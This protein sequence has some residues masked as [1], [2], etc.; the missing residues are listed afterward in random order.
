MDMP[1]TN[2]VAT[3]CRKHTSHMD[4]VT[5]STASITSTSLLNRLMMRPRG[6]VSKKARGRRKVAT[7]MP[8]WRRLEARRLPHASSSATEKERAPTVQQQ[9]PDCHR[10]LSPPG[11][12]VAKPTCHQAAYQSPNHERTAVTECVSS[13]APKP[14]E[15]ARMKESHSAVTAC[16]S[17]GTDCCYNSQC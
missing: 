3:T 17:T 9:S 14:P 13:C 2:T 5:A 15:K 12:S 4:N 1:I 11:Y 7:S 8:Q 6:V 10:N 16:G